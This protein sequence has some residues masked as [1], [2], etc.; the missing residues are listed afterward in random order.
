MVSGG[1]QIDLTYK[2]LP[3]Y[4]LN[5]DNHENIE[6]RIMNVEVRL[7]LNPQPVLVTRNVIFVLSP[8]APFGA[9]RILKIPPN[10]PFSK[11][12]VKVP[13]C[14]GGFRGI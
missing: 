8:H 3:V 4:F 14:K 12:G 1:K 5:P 2:A 11:G 7:V 13:L 9:P 6:Y 10:P